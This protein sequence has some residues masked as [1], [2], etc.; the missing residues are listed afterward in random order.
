M[1]DQATS[2]FPRDPESLRALLVQSRAELSDQQAEITRLRVTVT[3]HEALIDKLKLQLARLRRM[4]FGRSSEKLAAEIEQ[5]ELLIEELETPTPAQVKAGSVSPPAP[6]ADLIK[7]PRTLPEHLPREGVFHEVSCTCITCG[8]ALRRVGEDVSE[9]LEF[10]PEQWKVIR[11]VRPKYACGRCHTLAQAP[12]PIRPIS[13]SMAGPGLLA[14]V[15]VAKYCDHLPLYRQSEIY[16][17]S[18]VEI[19]RST[20]ADWVGG[21][22]ALLAPLVEILGSH[23][24]SGAK[25]H[26]DDTPVP[27]LSPGLG[28]TKTGR[29][30]TYVRDDRS[31]AGDAPP[32]V[33][34]RF[35]PD[36]KGEH[37]RHHLSGFVGTLQADGYAGFH[38]LYE[39][40]R[41]KEAACWAH[42]RRKF[43]DIH[44]A[45]GS[46]IAGEAIQR[47]GALYAIEKEIQGQP[48]EVRRE[49]RQARA[50]PH[51]DSF[52]AWLHESLLKLSVKSELATAIRY[53]TSRWPAL[54]RYRDDGTLEIDNNAAERALRAV[55]LGR[56]NFLFCG[57]DAGG[58]RAAAIYSL[59]GTAKLNG[60]DPEV[61]LRHV[62]ERIAEHPA[63]RLAELLPWNVAPLIEQNR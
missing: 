42:V 5:L 38:H 9:M 36:R 41:I 6:D 32:A 27:V 22:A 29:L 45:N 57:S 39:G 21:S 15:L 63:N 50:G 33:L 35:S 31:H 23:V 40:G 52:K 55:A 1:L 12:A 34:F 48:P 11:H 59:V 43:F 56:K 17:R 47:I 53:A 18:G 46:P 2:D 30:W 7:A 24:Y 44:H 49:V 25:L 20:L 8:G 19:E 58:E 28:K 16:A 51:L 61:Y 54:T 26:A 60:I 3:H 62:I 37:P 10:V 14:H 4:Q 13:R